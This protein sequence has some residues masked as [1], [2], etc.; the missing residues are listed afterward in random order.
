MS[1]RGAALP[2]GFGLVE[3][4]VALTVLSIG[5]LALA[6]TAVVA[7]RAF[8]SAAATERAVMAAAAVIDSLLYE[9]EPAAGTRVLDGTRVRWAVSRTGDLVRVETR[10]DVTAGSEPRSL[11]FHSTRLASARAGTDE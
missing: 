5:L 6:G 2:G 10:V 9:A 4:I 8:T 11:V 3:L 7:Q 1:A